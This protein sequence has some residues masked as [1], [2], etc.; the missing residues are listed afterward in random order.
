MF[1]NKE[2][3]IILGS[4]L[5]LNAIEAMVNDGADEVILLF[6]NCIL[7][8]HILSLNAETNQYF[9]FMNNCLV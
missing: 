2:C 6:H 3:L 4:N 7:I 5:V 1:L 8:S 9:K